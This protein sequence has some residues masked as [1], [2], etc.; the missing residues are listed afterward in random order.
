MVKIAPPTVKPSEPFAT[1]HKKSKYEDIFVV[2]YILTALAKNI[3]FKS[4]TKHNEEI[5]KYTTFLVLSEKVLLVLSAMP[6]SWHR[7]IIG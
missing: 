5:I 2:P 3:V 1:L 4:N 6:T 7:T